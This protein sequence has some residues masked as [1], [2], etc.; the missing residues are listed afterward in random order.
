WVTRARDAFVSTVRRRWPE[1]GL[2]LSLD[3]SADGRYHLHV[4]ALLP[5]HLD[6]GHLV[7]CWCRVAGG[8]R[9]AHRGR[10]AVRRVRDRLDLEH[11]VLDHDLSA[12]GRLAGAPLA[13]RAALVGQLSA[14]VR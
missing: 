13:L 12:A 3:V 7:V 11:H 4:I 8:A 10:G 2:L 5:R 14:R 9:V 6:P 1:A